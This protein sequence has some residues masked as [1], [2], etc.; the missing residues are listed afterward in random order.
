MTYYVIIAQKSTGKALHS[1]GRFYPHGD[2]DYR[3]I[4]PTME[5]ACNF[6]ERY[7]AAHQDRECVITDDQGVSLRVFR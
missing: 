6:S 1:N 3:C 7:S 4:F 2:T 5:A